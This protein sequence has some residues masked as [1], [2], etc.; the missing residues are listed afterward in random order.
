MSLK[1]S[2]GEDL[3][4]RGHSPGEWVSQYREVMKLREQGLGER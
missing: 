2:K 3:R 1:L 4:Y